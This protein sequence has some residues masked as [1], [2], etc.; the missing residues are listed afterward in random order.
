[1]IMPALMQEIG[2][3]CAFPIASKEGILLFSG[4]ASLLFI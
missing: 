3:R 1:M 4:S 2:D